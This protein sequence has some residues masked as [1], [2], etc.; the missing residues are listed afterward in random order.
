MAL[1]SR[2]DE[3]SGS[4]LCCSDASCRTRPAVLPPRCARYGRPRGLW[5][6]LYGFSHGFLVPL[7]S[8]YLA[9]LQW[10]TLRVRPLTPALWA[11]SL[12]LVTATVLLL[13]S[14]VAGI[15]TSG[16]LALI[17][18][19]AGLVLLLCGFA[20]LGVGFSAGL[21]SFYDACARRPD[22]AFGVAVS[23][24]QREHVRGDVASAR[25]PCTFGEPAV[26]HPAHGH[27]GS[28]AGM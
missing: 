15:I 13:A 1:V 24:P 18:V 8:L 25:H 19:L 6:N 27:A 20:Y 7:I 11:G 3:A 2:R 5:W 23:T 21:S 28:G 4:Q 12:W 22:P 10:P 14:E 9:W 26:H 16:S 17:L